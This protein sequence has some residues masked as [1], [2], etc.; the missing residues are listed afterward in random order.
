MEITRRGLLTWAG[1]FG[2]SSLLPGCTSKTVLTPKEEGPPPLGNEDFAQSVC[3]LCPAG[4]G[5]K[6]RRID[7]RAVGVS[8]ATG[9]PINQGTLCPKGPALLQELYHPDRLKSPM[10]RSGPRG[11]GAWTQISWEEALR[12]IGEK[13]SAA[14]KGAKL[15]ALSA[16]REWDADREIL[17]KLAQ[18]LG[19]RTFALGTPSSE[20]PIEAYQAMHGSRRISCDPAGAKLLVSFGLD[21]LQTLPSHV[22]AQQLWARMRTRGGDKSR[23]HVAQVEPRFSVTAGKADS[24]LP[25]RP[26]TED[27]LALAV[28][29]EMIAGGRFDEAFIRNHTL[30]FDAFRRAV[31]PFTAERVSQATELPEKDIR[32]LSSKF[33]NSSPAVAI[34]GRGT[35]WS[36]MAVH[37]L[38]AL[39]GSLGAKGIFSLAREAD[40]L[41]WATLGAKD[42]RPEVLLID[43]VNPAFVAP[44]P[45]K[46]VLEKAAF[47]V[48]VSPHM[49]ETAEFADIVLPCHTSLERLQSSKHRRLDGK[50]VLNTAARA[51][52]TRNASKDPGDIFLMIARAAGAQGMPARD[53]AS[54]V[55]AKSGSGD[56]SWKE[57][58]AAGERGSL[59]ATPSGRFEFDA[60]TA[61]LPDAHRRLEA[62][63]DKEFPLSLYVFTPLAFSSGEG[64]HLPFLQGIAGVQLSE[65]WESWAEMHPETAGAL[66]VSEGD[67]IWV[68]SRLG[69]I[70]VKARVLA[71]AKPGVVS[72]PFGLGHTAYGR[73]AK[74][75]GANPMDI[76][77]GPETSVTV[78]RA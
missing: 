17:G 62:A 75:V 3:D 16:P 72:I 26:G 29:H 19:G 25:V 68:R 60:L 52:E 12:V 55:A 6:V 15:A 54:Y 63:R 34:G 32:I 13:F 57:L 2:A 4:C 40:A 77:E 23:T 27:L 41:S 7:G 24:W 51:V 58:S 33:L 78:E 8:G 49:T 39:S 14:G 36:Q 47:V 73:W 21:W 76:A 46:A 69:K 45:W 48:V 70:P 10:L 31:E 9:H 50:I 37:A 38:N 64:A 66:G 1:I 44:A 5:L 74:G 71:W 20:P 11:S 43:R 42:P 22:E 67:K 35:P 61:A 18:S 56:T 53:F 59:F 65:K 30:G 28:A